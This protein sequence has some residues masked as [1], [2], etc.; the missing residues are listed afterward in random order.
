MKCAALALLTVPLLGQI[1]V[2]TR[3]VEVNVIVGDKNGPVRGLAKSDFEVFDRSKPRPIAFFTENSVA[4]RRNA[5]EPLPVNVFSNAPERRGLDPAAATVVLFDGVNTPLKDQIWAKLQFVAF[6]RQIRPRDRVAV[7]SLGRS[8]RVLS[9]FTNDAERLAA[10]V[11]AYRGRTDGSPDTPTVDRFETGDA[12]TDAIWNGF[13]EQ[14]AIDDQDR[15]V[16]VTTE[17]V[18]AIARQI[19]AIPGRKSL[20]WISAAFPFEQFTGKFPHLYAQEVNRMARALSAANVAMYPVD[21]RGLVG[22][23]HFSAETARPPG[24]NSLV[25]ATP[26]GHA[27]MDMLAQATGG[28]TFKNTN[29]VRGALRSVL[30]DAESTYTL[31]FAPDANDLDSTFHKLR[32]KVNRPGITARYREGYEA[33]PDAT[34]VDSSGIRLQVKV[35]RAEKVRLDVVIDARDVGA[36]PIEAAFAQ[37][38]VD[39]RDLATT[40][41]TLRGGAGQARAI[42]FV[43]EFVPVADAV[44]VRLVILDRASG[45]TGSITVPLH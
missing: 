30:D 21:A 18:E 25:F 44:E 33:V 12:K 29:D 8:L 23:P 20:I 42:G 43:K 34:P 19:G 36:G 2:T 5:P 35:D 41:S 11:A 17:A 27:V 13:L 37:R 26:I 45:R 1:R 39:G 24:V 28:R 3:L 14:E 9:D 15:R 32:V 31:A 10:T 38:S 6:L 22:M 7:Y 4:P 40:F 16:A